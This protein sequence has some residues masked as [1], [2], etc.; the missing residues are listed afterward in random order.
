[1]AAVPAGSAGVLLGQILR[2]WRARHGF[3]S[4]SA[5]AATASSPVP[6]AGDHIND[7]HALAC[8]T[9][10]LMFSRAANSHKTVTLADE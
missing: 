1:V 8:A 6:Q 4:R 9:Y 3:V 5:D 10:P 2:P 7:G